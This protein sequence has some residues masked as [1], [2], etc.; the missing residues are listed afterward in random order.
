MARKSIAKNLHSR[1]KTTAKK[2]G[3]YA[4]NSQITALL[5]REVSACRFRYVRVRLA[6][7]SEAA[8]D[9]SLKPK[10]WAL[11]EGKRGVICPFIRLEKKAQSLTDLFTKTYKSAQ[12]SLI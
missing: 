8:S 10:K 6:V 4:K 7:R 1:R 9:T 5:E 11:Y 2:A 3:F 12:N